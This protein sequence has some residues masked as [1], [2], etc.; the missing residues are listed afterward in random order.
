M[1]RIRSLAVALALSCCALSLSGADL[2]QYKEWDQSPAGYFMTR[3]ERAE[4]AKLGSEADAAAFVE[5]FLARRDGGFSAMVKERAA[6]A[7]KY[8]TIG[9]LP[10]SKT[11]R[12]KTI[13][14]FGPPSGLNLSERTK[15]DVK[16]DSPGMA[17][18]LSNLGSSGGSDKADASN[19]GGTLGTAQAIRVYSITFAGDTARLVDRKEVTFVIEADAATGKDRFPSRSAEKDAEELFE[20]VARASLKK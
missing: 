18:A 15:K 9:K 8:L 3:D 11:L 17:G 2:G 13:V 7:D 6:Q 16:R 5:A 14:L 4:W 10:G 20:L 1:H 12:G 19:L